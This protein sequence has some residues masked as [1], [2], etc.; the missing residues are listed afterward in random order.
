MQVDISLNSLSVHMVDQPG[1]RVP[2]VLSSHAETSGVKGAEPKNEDLVKVRYFRVQK[3]SPE[4]HTVY[5]GIDQSVTASL[6]T[7]VVHAAP[8]PII[9]LYD[10]IMSTFVPGHGGSGVNTPVV[11]DSPTG[12]PLPAPASADSGK[13]KVRVNLTTVEGGFLCYYGI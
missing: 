1:H 3:N 10:F 7:L 6:S 12:E 13:I 8:E 11:V 2:M 9:V 5:E 4:Y